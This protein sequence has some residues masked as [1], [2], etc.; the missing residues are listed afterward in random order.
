MT[1]ARHDSVPAILNGSMFLGCLHETQ[2]VTVTSAQVSCKERTWSALMQLSARQLAAA[3]ATSCAASALL[4]PLPLP[5]RKLD[6]F[7]ASATA[8][9]AM[10]A[11]AV[12]G[13][14]ASAKGLRRRSAAEWPLPPLPLQTLLEMGSPPF[15]AAGPAELAG[16]LSPGLR[17]CCCCCAFQ[18]ARASTLR[19][20]S[21]RPSCADAVSLR[22]RMEML[23]SLRT[24][25]PS[26]LLEVETA[27]LPACGC[28]STMDAGYAECGKNSTCRPPGE[29]VHSTATAAADA[30]SRRPAD[31]LHAQYLFI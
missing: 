12:N 29:T 4:L 3:L 1:Y 7:A 18:S 16:L 2:L 21:A 11:T 5:R 10:P 31:R 25:A 13:D 20:T 28:R 19:H 6:A 26:V 9:L 8:G 22:W 30:M 27:A 23:A 14:F 24:V 17:G 15:T